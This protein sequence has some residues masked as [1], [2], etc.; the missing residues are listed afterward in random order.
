[1]RGGFC[2]ESQGTER[3]AQVQRGIGILG[4]DLY[5][6]SVLHGR[7]SKTAQLLEGASQVVV[8]RG[9]IRV[10]FHRNFKLVYCLLNFALFCQCRPEA[11]VGVGIIRL[12][13]HCFSKLRD[14]LSVATFGMQSRPVRSK[15]FRIMFIERE[16]LFKHRNRF[17]GSAMLAQQLGNIEQRNTIGRC[18]LDNLLEFFDC[19]IDLT[20]V[21]QNNTLVVEPRHIIFQR[22][23]SPIGNQAIELFPI[24]LGLGAKQSLPL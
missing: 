21:F 10:L 13:R 1:M 17:L 5:C 22:S 24:G 11:V 2:S 9:V 19:G 18:H 6:F 3:F 16:Q 23:P 12:H 20:L 4:I 8:C 15:D 7:L 14:C